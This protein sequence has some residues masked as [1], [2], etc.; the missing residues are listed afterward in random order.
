VNPNGVT[1]SNL[2]TTW[3]NLQQTL[4]T[5][6]GVIDGSD[7]GGEG[8]GHSTAAMASASVRRGSR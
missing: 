2:G 1:N 6:N 3:N 5:L 7:V 4:V 8:N